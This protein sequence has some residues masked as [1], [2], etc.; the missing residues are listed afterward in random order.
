MKKRY[1]I[2]FCCG[3]L[4]V[5]VYC[6][7]IIGDLVRHTQAETITN[8]SESVQRPAGTRYEIAVDGAIYFCSDYECIAGFPLTI[9]M[10]TMSGATVTTRA[11]KS[12]SV[13]EIK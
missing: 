2:L 7:Y 8:T 10:H 1:S 11:G 5:G 13:T 12:I 6:G 9:I 3:V 4:I